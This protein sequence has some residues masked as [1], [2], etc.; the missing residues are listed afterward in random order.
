MLSWTKLFSKAKG[1]IRI[2]FID[3]IF[4]IEGAVS[5]NSAKLRNYKM[6]LKLRE[7]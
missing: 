6:S 4:Y 7:T 5:W 3:F 1:E 2:D